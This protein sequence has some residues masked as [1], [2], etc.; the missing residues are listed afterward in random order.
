MALSNKLRKLR[1]KTGESLQE[2]ADAVGVS[3]AHV[4]ELEAGR[5]T[6][7][8]LEL[9]RKL[10]TH[11]KVTVAHL[12]DDKAMPDEADALQFFR[13]YE[14]Q[15]TDNDWKTLRAVADSLKGKRK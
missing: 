3:K 6:N 15:L 14:G 10:A 8:G 7:P 5:S 2:V 4:W 13:A 1:L 11:F 12:S 9:L